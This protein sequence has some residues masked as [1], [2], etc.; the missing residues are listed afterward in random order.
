MSIRPYTIVCGIDLQENSNL[1]I[2]HALAEG[3]RHPQALIHFCTVVDPRKAKT[4]EDVED[5]GAR[6]RALVEEL[7]PTFTEEG[8]PSN[9]RLRYHIRAGR[10]EEQL[11]EL[12]FEARTDMIVVGGHSAAKRHQKKLRVGEFLTS[13]AHCSVQV[14]RVAD[15]NGVAEDYAS[16]AACVL[17][18]E[19]SEGSRWFCEKHS[20]G[21]IPRLSDK[22]GTSSYSPGW[23]IF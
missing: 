17:A 10:P 20:T 15:Y 6:L 13:A 18:R 12:A 9:R 11:L 14:V 7:L 22:V 2:E 3:V 4:D 5:A 23:G 19:K 8:V 21:R 16:C 1:V